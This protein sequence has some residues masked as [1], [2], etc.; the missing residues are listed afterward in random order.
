MSKVLTFNNKMLYRVASDKLV[1]YEYVQTQIPLQFIPGFSDTFVIMPGTTLYAGTYEFRISVPNAVIVS[2][3]ILEYQHWDNL[4]IVDGVATA[5]LT[6]DVYD[7]GG[8]VFFTYVYDSNGN[9][10]TVSDSSCSLWKVA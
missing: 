10:L 5:H 6:E 8:I 4:T 3:P 7:S 9:K 2:C 1:G